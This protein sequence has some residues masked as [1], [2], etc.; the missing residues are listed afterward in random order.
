MDR[1]Q[2]WAQPWWVNL[3]LLLPAISYL[4]WRRKG[5]LLSSAT[6]LTLAV[7]GASFGFVEAAVAVYLRAAAGVSDT[8]INA[9]SQLPPPQNYQQ[10]VSSLAQIP[11]NLRTIEVFREAATM[12][13]LGCVALLAGTRAKERWGG[14]LWTFAAWDITY[15][16]GLWTTLRWP[17][18]LK[19]Y[20]VLFLIPVPW[21]AQVWFPVLVSTLTMLAVALSRSRPL[22]SS[23]QNES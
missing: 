21:V 14:F 19:D 18:S 8:Y 17:S 13:M 7:F 9:T 11:Q 6:L 5:L 12:T 3:L 20:D 1:F 16:V 23:F 4:F 22:T 15:Y 10:V 2:L